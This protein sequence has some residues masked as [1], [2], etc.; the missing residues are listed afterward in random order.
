MRVNHVSQQPGA[1][2]EGSIKFYP[3]YIS[4]CL[5]HANVAGELLSEGKFN[6]ENQSN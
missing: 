6:N 2:I 5:L 3:S 4:E 1:F